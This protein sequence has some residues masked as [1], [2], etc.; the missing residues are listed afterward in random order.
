MREGCVWEEVRGGKGVRGGEGGRLE[1]VE[2]RMDGRKEGWK[3]G[4]GERSGKRM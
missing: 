1:S 4:G 2:A 3:E